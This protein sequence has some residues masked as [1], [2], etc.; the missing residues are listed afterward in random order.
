MDIRDISSIQTF[1][2]DELWKKNQQY[3]TNCH[4]NEFFTPFE[5]IEKMISHIPNHLWNLKT[6]WLE[7]T[8][9]QGYFL[10][11]VFNKLFHHE[12]CKMLSEEERTQTILSNLY[13]NDINPENVAIVKQWFN[14]SNLNFLDYPE[15]KFDVIIGNPPFHAPVVNSKIRKNKNICEK[16]IEKCLKML[17]PG[18]HMCFISPAAIWSGKR[19]RPGIYEKML[20]Y[21]PKHIY[22]NLKRWFSVGQNLKM[23]YFVL[24]NEERHLTAIETKCIFTTFLKA[25]I[26]PV[27]EWSEES[28]QLL[29]KYLSTERNGFKITN[30]RHRLEAEK[31]G[32]WGE[33]KGEVRVY[34]NQQR[35]FFTHSDEIIEEKYVLFRMKPFDCGVCEKCLLSSDI[36]FLPLTDYSTEEKE[37]IC[38]FFHSDDYQTLARV[39]TTSQYLKAGLIYYL[40]FSVM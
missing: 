22:F 14:V 10:L 9:G 25:R 3:K 12:N 21:Y 5:L 8:C 38:R 40:N 1:I 30:K 18:G 29:Q 34:Q 31:L 15:T 32:T 39:T 37:R 28:E 4:Y 11:V 23:C 16:I 2:K 7:P 36:Y 33:K 24:S 35:F 17:S 26:N 13:A 6:K 20:Q 19:S 27:E